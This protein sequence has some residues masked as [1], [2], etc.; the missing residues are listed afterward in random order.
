MWSLI[1]QLILGNIWNSIIKSSMLYIYMQGQNCCSLTPISAIFQLYSSIEVFL[2]ENTVTWHQWIQWF[3][4][5]L[6]STC[7]NGTLWFLVF[8][9][10]NTYIYDNVSVFLY[11]I[12]GLMCWCFTYIYDN[13]SVFLYTIQGLICWCFTYIYDSGSVFLYNIQDAICWYTVTTLWKSPIRVIFNRNILLVLYCGSK[14]YWWR[15]PKYLEKHTL[16]CCKLLINFVT[17]SCILSI[18]VYAGVI[19]FWFLVF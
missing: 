7:H 1:N 2:L 11:T 3:L 18:P 4:V 17:L 14:P 19:W 15:K 13:V 9:R 10:H 12:Q 8:F 5:F 6:T 16:I